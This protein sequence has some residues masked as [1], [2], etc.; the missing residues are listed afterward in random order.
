MAHEM[1][2]TQENFSKLLGLYAG[3]QVSNQQQITAARNAEIA[4]LGTTGP[5]RIDALSTFFRAYLGETEGKQFMS[6]VFTASDVQIAEK[7]VSKVSAQ[8]GGSFRAS[9]REPPEPAGRVSDEAYRAMTPAQRLDYARQFDQKQF[10]GA[11][12]GRS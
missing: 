11:P 1:G 9:G 5:A 2:I 3:A 4:K 8:G 10:N 12:M 6:R 7:I